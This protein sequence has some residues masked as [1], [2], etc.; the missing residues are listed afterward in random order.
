MQGSA[1]LML[2]GAGVQ[3]LG[4]VEELSSCLDIYPMLAKLVGFAAPAGQLDGVLPR[5]LGGAGRRYCISN[6]IYPEQTYKLSIRTQEHE[7]R[8]ETT[9]PTHH[10]GTVDMSR[11]SSHIY[12][13]DAAYEEVFDAALHAEFLRIAHEHTASFH[14]KWEE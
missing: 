13:R 8:L 11:F 5:A 9:R 3:H 6:S 4:T 7:F 1:A 10:D 12:T 14:E 2:R